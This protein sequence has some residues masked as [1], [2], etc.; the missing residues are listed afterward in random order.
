MNDLLRIGLILIAELLVRMLHFNSKPSVSH[1]R[2]ED[3]SYKVLVLDSVTKDIVAPL[4]RVDELRNNGVTLHMQIDSERQPIPDVAAVYFVEP[5]EENITRIAEDAKQGLY[6][7]FHLNFSSKVS[8]SMME[9]LATHVVEGGASARIAQVYDQYAKFI[10]LDRGLFSLGLPSVYL[11][12]NDP[13]SKDTVIENTICSVV[14]GIFCMLATSGVV[15]IL[16]SPP[17]GAAE[18][19]ARSL[20]ERLREALQSRTNLFSENTSAGLSTSLHRPLLCLFDRNFELS[21]AVQHSWAYKPLVHDVLG[22]KLNRTSASPYLNGKSHDLDSKDTFWEEYGKEQFPKIAEQVESE[23]KQYKESVEE[24]NRSTGA[25]IDPNVVIDPSDL[26]SNST[27]GL[28]SALTALPELTERKKN[29][30]KHTNIATA[31]LQV[32][33]ERKLDHYYSLEEDLV[34]GKHTIQDVIDRMN[35]SEGTASDKLRLALVWLL[36]MPSAP[37]EE[38]CNSIEEPLKNSGADMAAWVYVKRMRRMN[39]MGKN[40][41]AGASDP[42]IGGQFAADFLG[43]SF[44]QGLTNLTKGVKNLLTGQQEAAVTVALESLMDGKASPETE[45]YLFL[46]PKSSPGNAGRSQSAFKDAIVFLIGGGNY[47]EWASLASWA[48]RA[49]PA[50]KSI[51]YGATELINGEDM[52]NGLAELGRRSGVQQ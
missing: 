35:G 15:P 5:S 43:S 2:T 45:G 19:V 38:E 49:Q 25:N 36:T 21:V 26:M 46:D 12:L 23:L 8:Q 40:K 30:D 7:T 13:Q 33:K 41:S 14:D 48:A 27:K 4:L 47:T 51:V 9:K 42:A 50:P 16:C 22:L 6:D 28:K 17:G 20:D 52:V 10:S 1:G 29:I 32:I 11:D 34:A 24:L 3:E 18:H 31:L 44:G 37:T 39:L